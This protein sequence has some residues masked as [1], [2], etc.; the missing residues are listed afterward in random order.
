MR[1]I[2]IR[3][4][5]NNKY[6]TTYGKGLRRSAVY[7]ATAEINEPYAKYLLDFEPGA[8]WVDHARTED[9]LQTAQRLIDQVQRDQELLWSWV[10]WY[11]RA[12]GEKEF[13]SGFAAYDMASEEIALHVHDAQRGITEQWLLP[14]RRCQAT[15]GRN[16]PAFLATNHD[17]T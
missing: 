8:A 2:A 5:E 9:Q 3:L 4:F 12:S 15:A 6:G 1:P 16:S 13:V 7:N 17:L 14:L 10:K 11:D